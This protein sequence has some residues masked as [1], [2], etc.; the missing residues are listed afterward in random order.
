MRKKLSIFGLTAAM[1]IMII[2]S[3][4]RKEENF[5][6]DSSLKLEFSADTIFFDTVF[7][8]VG[9]VTLQIRVFNPTND[10]V[11]IS[12][13]RIMGST[14]S[15]YRINVNGMSGTAFQDVEIGPRDSIFIFAEVTVDPGNINNPF[16]ITDSIE[17]LTNGNYQYVS[18]VAWG[19]DAYFHYPDHPE[20]Q[21]LP[22]YSL[23]GGTWAN[24]KPH[25]VYG[26][27]VVDEDSVLNI[28]AGTQVYMHNDAVLWV[29]DGGSLRINGALG[30]E[31]I[32]TGDRLDE[33]YKDLPGMWGK[34]WLSAGSIDNVIDYAIIKNGRIGIQVDTTGA[35]S[36]PTLTISNTIIDNMSTAAFY[37]QGSYVKAENC[38][39]GSAGYYSLV[40]A[41]GGDY[42]FRHCSVGNYWTEST[43]ST[44][45]L[46][47][48]NYYEDIYGNIQIRDL[49][50]AYF[51]NCIIYGQNADEMLL[52]AYSGGGVFNFTFENCLLRTT[53]G[54]SG[55]GYTNCYKNQTPSFNDTENGDYSIGSGSF[56]IDKGSI[57]GTG[58]IALDI[59]GNPRI[60]GTAPD[61]GAW[62]V[63]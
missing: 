19:Q 62:E 35:S 11:N 45:A 61:L 4:C 44:P 58:T 15:N 2:A 32:F 13:V 33:Y 22:A 14:A 3:S 50:N 17:F 56:A 27:A 1:L 48:N 63:Q 53:L 24:D 51:G 34:I 10:Y 28:Q 20:T 18:L 47:L 23:V 54:T 37:A 38:V 9:S 30:N 46:V 25:V 8:T 29:Y 43:R 60:S 57:T 36:N 6:T 21:Y 59:A 26:Y 16:V 40:L 55:A 7:S 41:I 5:N 39:F 49:T 12:S 31:V 52:D 42:D